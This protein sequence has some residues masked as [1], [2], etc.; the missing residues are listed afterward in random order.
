MP[1]FAGLDYGTG[2]AKACVI[3]DEGVVRGYAFAEL[4]LYHTHPGWSEHDA[5]VYWPL[6]CRLLQQAIAQ[7]GAPASDVKGV[8]LSSAMPCLVLVDAQGEP[9]A[10]AYNL[11]DRRASAQ[12]SSLYDRLGRERVYDSIGNRLEDHPT[13]VNL[14][15]ETQHRPELLARAASALTIDGYI[16]MR[17][18]GARVIHRSGAGFYGCYNLRQGDWDAELLHQAGVPAALL[19]RLC[20]CTDIVGEVTPAASRAT[21]LA[22]GT[23]VAAGQV[24]CNAGWV[25]A[26]ATRIGD[27]QSNLGTV[28]NFGV[29][30]QSTDFVHSDVG[31]LMINVPYTIADTLVTIPTTMTGGQSIRYLRD[32]FGQHELALERQGGPTAYD[33]LNLAASEVPPGSEGLLVLPYLMGE[34]T[35][36]WD[37]NARGVLFGLSLNH[38]KGHLVRAMMEAVAYAMYDSYRLIQQSGLKVNLPLVLNEGGAVSRLWRQIIADVFDVPIVLVQRREGAPFGDALLAGVATGHLAGLDTSREWTTYVDPIEPD[39]A[40]HRLYQEHFALY[41]QLYGHLKEDFQALAA[42]RNR[43]AQ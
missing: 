15:W 1:L 39:P 26:G 5:S 3:D 23:P 42:L 20:A 29:V 32:A 17:L 25:G 7:T 35:P 6:A 16:T 14:M 4:D 21:G 36:L 24:D 40:R 34:R 37:V 10:R 41:R 28:G 18:C 38:G 19:P 2:G 33:Q 31:R 30:H 12:V 11:M 8:A 43:Y 22:V 13:I 9:L 27:I